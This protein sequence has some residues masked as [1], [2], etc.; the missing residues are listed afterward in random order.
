[1]TDELKQIKKLYGEDMMHLCR[2]LFPTILEKKGK[3]LSILTKV[4]FPTH[5]IC[6]DLKESNTVNDFQ[7]F[8]NSLNEEDEKR[9]IVVNES[10]KELL[11]KVNY[12]LYECK[13]EEDIQS[14]KDSG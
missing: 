5:S 6:K 8:I 3:L 2:S 13:T 7:E 1:M 4:F 14:F 11:S 10:P 9:L 12:D